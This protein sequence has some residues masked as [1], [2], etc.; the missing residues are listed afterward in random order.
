[1]T[2]IFL[3]CKVLHFSFINDSYDVLDFFYFRLIY[4]LNGFYQVQS[5]TQLLYYTCQYCHQK[6]KKK[7]INNLSVYTVCRMH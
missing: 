7:K 5:Y 4:E 6:A 1:M 3:S 2:R